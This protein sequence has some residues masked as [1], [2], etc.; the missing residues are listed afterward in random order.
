M[1][2]YYMRNKAKA[3]F[4]NTEETKTDQSQANDADINVIVKRYGQ[5]GTVPG[6]KTPPM[7]GDFSELPTNLMDVIES[8]KQ[9]QI[10][11]KSLPEQL[12]EIPLD[13]LLS[14]TPDEIT[15]LMAPP[16]DPPAPPKE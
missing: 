4:I 9:M 11:R 7:Y 10:M 16:A 6:M 12:R 2:S 1:R 13:E 14:L 5:T 8:G 15:R 3:V